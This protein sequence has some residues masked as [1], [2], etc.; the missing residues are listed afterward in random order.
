MTPVNSERTIVHI[1]T[2]NSRASIERCAR[3]VVTQK[4]F[5]EGELALWITDNG[6][7]DG[8]AELLNEIASRWPQV[9]VRLNKENLGFCA[10]HN[11]AITQFLQ[12][13]AEY[14]LVLNPDI[15]LQP[16]TVVTLRDALRSDYL[17]GSV[18]PKLL[19]CDAELNPLHPARIDAAGMCITP[20][21]RH[22]D[23][24]SGVVDEGQFDTPGYVFGG[25][26]ACLL[27][28]RAAIDS[29]LLPCTVYD[30]VLAEIFPATATGLNERRQL[31]DEAFFAYREDAELAW[32]AQRLGWRCRY[33]PDALAYHTRV[34]VPERR[35]ELP[36]SLNR[37]SVR[38]RFLLQ[39][40]H[41]SPWVAWGA[42]IEGCIVRNLLVLLGVLLTERS[43]L[44]ALREL[45]YLTPRAL[46]IRKTI[47]R[48]ATHTVTSWLSREL[49]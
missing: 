34:V 38:N 10:G 32:R 28:R 31:F 8:T 18:T 36:Q 25:T 37:H 44:G 9:Q 14:F 27:L 17:A 4:G 35:S 15:G 33:C 49:Q 13:S 2:F 41:Y 19:R 45:F 26:G 23:R 7:H 47:S 12:S 16:E 24:G 42:A 3:S 21:L 22:L 6:S 40:N 5:T 1:L 43:S 11:Q 46:S 30:P 39:L 29:L 48:R 20:E